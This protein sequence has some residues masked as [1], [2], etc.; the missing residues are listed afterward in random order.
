MHNVIRCGILA[1]TLCAALVTCPGLVLAESGSAGGSIGNDEKT[2]SG[3][4]SEPSS[5]RDEPRR[6]SRKAEE[7]RRSP[8]GG[9]SGGSFDG[10]WSYT[11]VATNC[12]GSGSGTLVIAGGLISNK[13]G[14]GEVSPNGA[15]HSASVGD[16]GVAMTATG[17]MSG[18]A[19]S[20]SFRR[21]DGC[22][23]RWSARRV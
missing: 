12:Q 22:V 2:L 15:Y 8:H 20:G 9:G 23:G 7:P 10:T 14:T 5:N 13:N 4:R 21:A 17:R 6:Q 16:D 19:G 11:G 3:A 1:A 18:N